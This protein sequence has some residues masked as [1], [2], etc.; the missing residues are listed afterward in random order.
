METSG[1]QR[2]G[3]VFSR[4]TISAGQTSGQTGAQTDRQ[5]SPLQAAVSPHAGMSI[6]AY[7]RDR[8]ITSCMMMEKLKTSPANEPPWTG[9]LRSSGATHNSS[10]RQAR[11]DRRVGKHGRLD[12]CV[13]ATLFGF[14]KLKVLR[15]KDHGKSVVSDFQNKP[16]VN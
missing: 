2:G 5:A 7:G 12:V 11:S 15:V 8:V 14:M 3:G 4:S 13:F 10:D 9:F 1:L 6:M 16:A